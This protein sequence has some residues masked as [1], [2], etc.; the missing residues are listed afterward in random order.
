M[1]EILYSACIQ[2]EAVQNIESNLARPVINQIP[3]QSPGRYAAELPLR[4]IKLFSFQ[5]N[6]PYVPSTHIL[7]IFFY[8]SLLHREAKYN[9]GVLSLLPYFN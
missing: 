6:S 7:W 8:A 2:P 5:A 4:G 9:L 1:N 3:T